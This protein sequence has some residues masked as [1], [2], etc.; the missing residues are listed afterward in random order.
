ML[1][2]RDLLDKQ[3]K[4]RDGKKLGKVDGMVMQ[5]SNSA[6]PPRI[7]HIELG[8]IV[9]ARRIGSRFGALWEAIAMSIGGR[10]AR[11]FRISCR[12][13]QFKTIEIVAALTQKDTPIPNWQSWLRAHL[14]RRIPGG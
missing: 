7:T 6:K 5:I 4:D 10:S 1:L 8:S 13:L 11:P 2:V 12:K 14:V 3:L 9:L